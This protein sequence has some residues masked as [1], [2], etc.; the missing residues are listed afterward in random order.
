MG[1]T[2]LVIFDCDG[3]LVDSEHLSVEVEVGILGDLGWEITPSEIAERF[4]GISD[5][6]YVAKIEDHLGITLP[7]SWLEEMAPRYRAAFERDLQPVDGIVAA[8]D[9]LE[10]ADIR[11][12]VASSGTPEKM[13]FTL[14]L[15]GLWDRFEGRIFSATE[16]SRGKPAPDL[17]LHAASRIGVEPSR[18]AVVEDSPAGVQAALAAG[19]RTI[20]YAGGLVPLERL[21]LPGVTVISDMR[22]LAPLLAGRISESESEG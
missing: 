15:T 6:D 16:V 10:S 4:L 11:T 22:E 3:V 5:A 9:D 18:C 17:F 21:A 7:P 14:G 12:S 1:A 8:L 2:E 13:R 20:A 19:M